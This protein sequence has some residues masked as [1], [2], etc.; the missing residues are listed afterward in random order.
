MKTKFKK[1]LKIFLY[2][3]VFLAFALFLTH[4]SFKRYAEKS[5][6]RAKKEKPYDVIIVPG[7]PYEKENT[8]SVML[9]RILWAK[10]L[11]DSGYTRNVIFSGAAVYSPYVEGIAMKIIADSLGIPADHTFTETEAEHST[12]NI[13]YSWKLAK[14]MGY[15]KI[16]LATDPF[17]SRMLRSFINKF[18]PGVSSVPIVFDKIDMEA[19]PL[20]PIN[21]D[22]AFR[23]EFVSIMEREGFWQRLRGTMGRRIK[24][25]VNGKEQN[26]KDAAGSQ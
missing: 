17:Q 5:Y 21:F 6:L 20:P 18:C 26:R 14:N 23:R 16:A 15:K 1:F 2:F 25:E 7:V 13:Y 4:C 22:S 3:H 11:Y 10:H 8:T 19:T 9:M 12:E 24:A